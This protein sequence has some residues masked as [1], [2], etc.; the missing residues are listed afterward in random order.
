MQLGRTEGTVS[1]Y[2]LDDVDGNRLTDAESICEMRTAKLAGLAI[3]IS[4]LEEGCYH[5]NWVLKM[6]STALQGVCK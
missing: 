6:E 4:D 5:K 3:E 1:V 2:M